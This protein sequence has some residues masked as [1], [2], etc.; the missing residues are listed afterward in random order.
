MGNPDSGSAD[1]EYFNALGWCREILNDAA[2]QYAP[3]PSREKKSST[4]DALF[5]ETLKT[6][7]TLSHCVSTYRTPANPGQRIEEFRTLLSLGYQLNGYPHVAH[8]GV[9]CMILDEV[10]AL[11][12]TYNKDLEGGPIRYSTVTA[13]LQV[14]FLKALRTPQVVLVTA[15]IKKIEGRKHF[16]EASI[17][18]EHRVAIATAEALFMRQQEPRTNKL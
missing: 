4:E 13:S 9:T 12:L 5:A 11:L 3:T 1:L 8:G 14:S 2:F 6:P 18:D 10:C 17:Q 16:I 7:D 15:K